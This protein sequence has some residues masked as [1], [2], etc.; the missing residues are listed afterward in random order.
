MHLECKLTLGEGGRLIIP[1]KIRKHLA[2]HAGDQVILVLDGTLQVIPVKEEIKKFQ[3]LVKARN[4]NN[5]S[6]V[7]SLFSTRKQELLDE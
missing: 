4:K 5:V 6:L 1:A 2:L 3:A 7:E